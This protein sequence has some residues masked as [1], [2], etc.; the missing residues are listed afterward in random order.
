MGLHAAENHLKPSIFPLCNPSDPTAPYLTT[1]LD[2]AI[3]LS[4]SLVMRRVKP[5]G[6][7]FLLPSGT[8]LLLYCG[9]VPRTLGAH[10]AAK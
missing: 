8:W 10:R 1:Y 9:R 2:L 5:D 6:K 7:S 4:D 3:L